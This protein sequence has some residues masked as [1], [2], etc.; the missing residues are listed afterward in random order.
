MRKRDF[1]AA[2][3]AFFSIP[4]AVGKA[5][6]S[7][8]IGEFSEVKPEKRTMIQVTLNEGLPANFPVDNR[9]PGTLKLLVN[10]KTFAE[11][12]VSFSVQTTSQGAL[13]G[14]LIPM[15]YTMILPGPRAGRE[16]RAIL[17]GHMADHAVPEIEVTE[18]ER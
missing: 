5:V 13:S 3:A 15:V 17:T 12:P 1:I 14:V 16:V 10:G 2:C 7:N 9:S 11:V 8:P 6:P 18:F 4:F